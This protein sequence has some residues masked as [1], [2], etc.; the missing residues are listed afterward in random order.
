MT[1]LKPLSWCEYCDMSPARQRDREVIARLDERSQEAAMRFHHPT[2]EQRKEARRRQK[3][4]DRWQPTEAEIR[5]HC[6]LN[7]LPKIGK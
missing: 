3:A 5:R 6:Q 2:A 7:G 1:K 4:L